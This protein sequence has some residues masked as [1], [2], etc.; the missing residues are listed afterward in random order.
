MAAAA[1]AALTASQ[2]PGLELVQPGGREAAG[3]PEASDLPA[4]GNSPYHTELPPLVKPDKPGSSSDLPEATGPAESGIPA[5]VLAA[6]KRAE[7]TLGE[8]RPGCNLPWQ[9]LAAIGKVE[10]GQARGGAVD[11]Q[12]TTHKPILGPALNGV[13][14]AHI[15]DTDGGAYDGDTR[16]DRAVGP[17]QFIPSTWANWG[18][19]GNGDGRKD[20][21]NIYDAALAAGRYLC[22][23]GRNLSDPADLERA[24]LS[25]NQSRE[26]LRTVLSWLDFYRKGA[27]EVPDGEGVLPDS[28]GA[29]NESRPARPGGKPA[30]GSTER[31]GE[32]AGDRK[33]EGGG[34]KDGDDAKPSPKPP[35]SKDGTIAPLPPADSEEPEAPGE[36]PE[37]PGNPEEPGEDP[38][39]PGEEPET[40]EEPGEEP[41]E[42]GE[43]PEEPGEEPEEPG[44]DPDC[45][46]DPEDPGNPEEPG[47]STEEPAGSPSPT[48]SGEPGEESE[49]SGDPE[50]PGDDPEDPGES[51]EDPCGD[52]DPGN[53]DE[54]GQDEGGSGPQDDGEQ[55]PAP[56]AGATVQARQED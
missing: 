17:M 40:P 26:Y 50:Q 12:G 53:P 18:A 4:D 7:R 3:S 5:T 19:D 11:A 44:E 56:T 36:E 42:P 8:E 6:Y 41:E 31:P 2:G 52:E 27:H 10:S 33:N 54:P 20:P 51:T 47:E 21:N 23:G 49:D 48:P 22:A 46:V 1:M 32:K 30:A 29:G 14:F 39:Q 9:L 15:S 13:G 37:Q 35:V 38:E 28:P 43:E 55:T 24:I 45:P 16:Y 34:G 25:Y